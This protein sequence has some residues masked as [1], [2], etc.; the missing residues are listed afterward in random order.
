MYIFSAPCLRLCVPIV[1][2][3]SLTFTGCFDPV[4]WHPSVGGPAVVT[5]PLLGGSQFRHRSS[6]LCHIQHDDLC[7]FS[8]SVS[9]KTNFLSRSILS[10]QSFPLSSN[11]VHLA[12]LVSAVDSHGLTN[13]IFLC[14]LFAGRFLILSTSIT[15]ATARRCHAAIYLHTVRAICGILGNMRHGPSLSTQLA[16]W[17]FP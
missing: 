12:A 16:V 6:G 13:C 4:P 15:S 9:E 3:W 1:F 7:C 17:V 11:D 2:R 14:L 10:S 5:N 8:Q